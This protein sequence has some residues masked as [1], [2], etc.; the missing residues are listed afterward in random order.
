METRYVTAKRVQLRYLQYV[1]LL[2]LY[3]IKCVQAALFF[4]KIK[5]FQFED[6]FANNYFT[7]DMSEGEIISAIHATLDHSKLASQTDQYKVQILHRSVIKVN[8]RPIATIQSWL[9]VWP[10]SHHNLSPMLHSIENCKLLFMAHSRYMFLSYCDWSICG[11]YISIYSYKYF[12]TEI[13]DKFPYIFQ[14]LKI[15]FLIFWNQHKHI[16]N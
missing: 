4:Y 5:H 2:L 12:E 10:L 16:E 6:N 8:Y 14:P 15:E 9:A 11:H 1:L 7:C 13:A 3:K